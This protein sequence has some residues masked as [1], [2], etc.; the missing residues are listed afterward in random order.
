MNP[1]QKTLIIGMPTGSGLIPALMVQ[2]LLQLHKPLPAAFIY[3][4][5]QLVEKARNEIVL[6]ALKIPSCAYVLFVD[7]DNPIPTDTLDK[8]MEADKDIIIAAIPTRSP[9][10]NGYHK[11]CAFYSEEKEVGGKKI[12]TYRDIQQFRDPGPLHRID[13][14][15]TG[16]MLIKRKVLE[17]MN[18]KYGQYMFE[19][20]VIMLDEPVVEN[21]V[22]ID[23]RTMSEDVQFCERAVDLGFEIWLDE[24]IR[25]IHLGAPKIARFQGF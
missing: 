13:A 4:E 24:R 15:G 18:K 23:R 25:P 5:R 10:A 16:C 21:G 20:G 12:R 2:S 9:D 6:E 8:M 11:L 22:T 14:G 17:A 7:D 19:R 3:I 1:D